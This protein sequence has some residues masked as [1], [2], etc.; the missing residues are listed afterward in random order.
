M[1]DFQTS[2]DIAQSLRWSRRL[3]TGMYLLIS[4]MWSSVGSAGG[5]GRGSG[6]KVKLECAFSTA[7]QEV[8]WDATSW[9]LGGVFSG[10]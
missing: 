8:V 6:A 5:L 4:R 1:H 10:G 3:P 2:E 9:E 7:G